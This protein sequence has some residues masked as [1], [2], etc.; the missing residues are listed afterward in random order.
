MGAAR[1]ARRAGLTCRRQFA[2]IGGSHRAAASDQRVARAAGS[3]RAGLQGPVPGV[4]TARAAA[5]RALLGL[6]S[7]ARS[8]HGGLRSGRAGLRGFARIKDASRRGGV[9]RSAPNRTTPQNWRPRRPFRRPPAGTDVSPRHVAGDPTTSVPPTAASSDHRSHRLPRAGGVPRTPA[10]ARGLD[11]QLNNDP[12]PDR[13]VGS[14]RSAP[15]RMERRAG[16]APTGSRRARW[17][18]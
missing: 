7:S 3:A 18:R 2:R 5:A 17:V 14:Q 4:P 12:P 13:P 6:A 15:P 16:G 1:H 9:R 8:L 10:P 11:P